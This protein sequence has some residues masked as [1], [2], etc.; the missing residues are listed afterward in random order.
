MTSRRA[1]EVVLD[2][3]LVIDKPVG[4][5][6]FDVVRRVRH[7]ARVR[8][9]GHGGTLDPLASGVLPV[10]LGEA[11]KLAPFL[12]DADKEYEFTVRLGIETDTYDAAGAVTATAD[13]SGVDE[14]RVR[15][16]LPAFTGAISQKP[17]AYSALKRDGRPLYDYA[18]A[19]ELVEVAPRP[20]TVHELDLVAW[21]GPEAVGLRLRCSKG[22]Y[23]R[24][25]AFD[26]GRALG[27]GGHVTA[28]RRT[29]SGP[30]SL[31]VAKSL[32]EV[33]A[34]FPL[35]SG[36]EAAARLG[37]VRLEDALGHLPRC[38]V[39]AAGALMLEQG[40]RL[41]VAAVAL[42]WGS[43]A[44][45]A[46][47]RFCVLRPDGRLLAVATVEADGTLKTQRVFGVAESA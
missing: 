6:S 32:D 30:F 10:C 44:E 11:T 7:A 27:V 36:S 22:T 13:A 42:P 15:A 5:T 33:L 18:R 3:V 35:E 28:L 46:D 45:G 43:P 34:A 2:G 23:V 20:V 29:R 4:P 47:A 17:P 21:G 38:S 16:A 37:L 39:D 24:S 14:A 40:K 8:R 31:A 1:P 25:L 41:P 26:L 19:G 12:L 9:C